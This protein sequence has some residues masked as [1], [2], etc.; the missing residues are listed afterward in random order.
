MSVS[1]QCVF[2]SGVVTKVI[3]EKE[4]FFFFLFKKPELLAHTIQL[5]ASFCFF[6]LCWVKKA[7]LLLAQ[8]LNSAHISVVVG[9]QILGDLKQWHCASELRRLLLCCCKHASI[10]QR[11]LLLPAQDVWNMA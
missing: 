6:C 10:G 2:V 5:K 4:C 11:S 7:C 1:V 3:G 8:V 9:V